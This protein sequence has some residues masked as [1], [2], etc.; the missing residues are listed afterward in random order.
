M[1]KLASVLM[2][3]TAVMAAHGGT[4]CILPSGENIQFNAPRGQ[5]NALCN[6]RKDGLTR[7]NVHRYINSMSNWGFKR[8]GA[9]WSVDIVRDYFDPYEFVYDVDQY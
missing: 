8:S 9:T 5:N 2:L 6:V 7:T 3:T 1:I 4:H